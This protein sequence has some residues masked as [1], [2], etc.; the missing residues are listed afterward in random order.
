LLLQSSAIRENRLHIG[1]SK[2]L[3]SCI[4]DGVIE[5][6][7]KS[8]E[9]NGGEK[10]LQ[11]I[12]VKNMS[13]INGQNKEE[14]NKIKNLVLSKF[15]ENTS[16]RKFTNKAHRNAT[17]PLIFYWSCVLFSYLRK[18]RKTSKVENVYKLDYD[19]HTAG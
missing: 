18:L 10:D 13:K 6:N 4:R 1:S 19:K 14:I 16:S 3:E 7:D 9:K 17:A 2:S 15:K 5:T 8:L 12:N 11:V